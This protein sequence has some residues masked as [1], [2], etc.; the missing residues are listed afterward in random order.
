[1]AD[2]CD[3]AQLIK[4]YSQPTQNEQRYSP[5]QMVEA[6]P[7][8]VYSMPPESPITYGLC[9]K[10]WRRRRI[11]T[12]RC[13]FSVPRWLQAVVVVPQVLLANGG[14]FALVAKDEER[15]A[16]VQNRGCLSSRV[17]L[18]HAVHLQG[19]G[20]F[21]RWPRQ[22]AVVDFHESTLPRSASLQRTRT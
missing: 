1:M 20:A 22:S 15:L 19:L 17:L 6:V 9:T 5:A 4:F 7:V 2:R 18:H 14:Y 8:A 13:F 21:P 12:I 3:F 10:S 16:S 11:E